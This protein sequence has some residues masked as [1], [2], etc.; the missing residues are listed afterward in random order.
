MS[1]D[2][3]HLN[4]FHQL[5]FYLKESKEYA[6]CF[7]DEKQVHCRGKFHRIPAVLA[8]ASE[9]SKCPMDGLENFRNFA[10]RNIL[11]FYYG[12]WKQ[13]CHQMFDL[14]SHLKLLQKTLDKEKCEVATDLHVLAFWFVYFCFLKKKTLNSKALERSQLF[15]FKVKMF[16]TYF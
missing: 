7:T 12:Y 5:V 14:I 15:I 13:N 3:C 16:F 6:N 4:L 8:V 11:N 1:N 2:P 9:R 10:I